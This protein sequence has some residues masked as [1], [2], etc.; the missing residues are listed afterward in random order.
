MHMSAN[1]KVKR[2]GKE[3]QSYPGRNYTPGPRD[4][5]LEDQG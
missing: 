1:L 2:L 5:V 3:H 4:N